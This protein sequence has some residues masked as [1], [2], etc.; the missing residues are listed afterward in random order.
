[1]TEQKRVAASEY[2]RL[3]LESMPEK[4]LV[5]VLVDYASL[6]GWRVHHCRP[7][8]NRRGEWSTPIQ[9]DKGFPDL[10]LARQGMIL[11]R[12]VKTEKGRLTEAQH[13]WLAAFGVPEPLGVWRPSDWN[14]I[15]DELA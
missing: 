9:G 8:V 13:S 15:R 14:R 5:S 11:V 3:L 10:I 4:E 12:E 7:A 2:N 1:M 6:N